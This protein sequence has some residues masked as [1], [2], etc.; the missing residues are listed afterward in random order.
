MQKDSLLQP[1]KQK[2]LFNV[3]YQGKEHLVSS[4]LDLRSDKESLFMRVK[5]FDAN[6]RE[7]KIADPDEIEEQVDEAND[8]K[9]MMLNEPILGDCEI[10]FVNFEDKDAKSAF[11]HSSAHI[12]GYALEQ[13]YE[14]AQLTIGPPIKDGFFYDFLPQD[15][16]VVKDEQDYKAIEKAMKTII[17]QNYPFE[18]LLVTKEQALDLFSYNKFKTELIQKKVQDDDITSVFRIG[19]FIDLCTGPHIPSTKHVKAFKI[20]KHSQAYW[21]GDANRDSLQRVYGISFPQKTMLADYLKV[22]EEAKRRDHRVLGPAQELFFFSE[23]APGSPFFLPNGTKIYNKL[24]DFMQNQYKKR[25]YQEVITPNLCDIDLW[26]VSGHYKN[27]KENLYL[28][29]NEDGDRVE[30]QGLKPMNC[31]C[32]CLIFKNST[33][34][35]KELPIRLADFGVLHRNE[36][37][38]ALSGLTRVRRFQQDDAHIFCRQDQI[39]EEVQGCL[40]FLEQVYGLFGFKFELFLST[41]PEDSLGSDLLWEQAES[42]LKAALDQSGRP[43]KLS[44]GDGAFYGPKIDIVIH[45]ALDRPLQCG[46][47][48][49]DFQLPIRFNL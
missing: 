19:E 7:M 35:Y 45:D 21:L 22:K 10:D 11:W 4:G 27:Y 46:T 49:L 1:M 40:E 26:K 29:R 33:H 2:P 42:Q 38:G 41:R 34:S 6:I 39:E 48:Q 31:P 20:T 44:K 3:R 30:T 5:Y 43:W 18:K 36:L 24:I 47:I 23:F 15:N 14:G 16:T 28:L 9:L 32:H 8:W 12:L 13:V 37:S 25:G 17:G